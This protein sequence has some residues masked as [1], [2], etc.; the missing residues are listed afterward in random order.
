MTTYVE[1]AISKNTSAVKLLVLQ[2]SANQVELKK[3]GPVEKW[4]HKW[5]DQKSS[6]YR[7]DDHQPAQEAQ[8][9][10][11]GGAGKTLRAGNTQAAALSTEAKVPAT[12]WRRTA[13]S[14][15]R[16]WASAF[17]RSNSSSAESCADVNPHHRGVVEQLFCPGHP[18]SPACRPGP[19]LCSAASA[20][21]ARPLWAASAPWPSFVHICWTAARS[22]PAV[23]SSKG[24][25]SMSGRRG[26]ASVDEEGRQCVTE[27]RQSVGRHTLLA[28]H[29]FF[30][31][32]LQITC[33]RS[34]AAF[35]R[36]VSH[37]GYCPIRQVR[38]NAYLSL[39]I[40]PGCT[41]SAD[42][43]FH[44]DSEFTNSERWTQTWSCL[45]LNFLVCFD[46]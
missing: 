9:I 1:L 30:W 31:L 34:F 6:K 37:K 29:D 21:A 24:I 39:V 2:Q 5:I 33:G 41:S 28:W 15:S 8:R 44:Y 43:K 11:S 40:Q 35:W 32:S 14:S 10:H 38:C 45:N 17:S 16:Q 3:P 18:P 46:C 7:D 12:A 23:R 26:C 25:K 13:A 19:H 27:R 20:C 4:K 22:A 42:Q 36:D